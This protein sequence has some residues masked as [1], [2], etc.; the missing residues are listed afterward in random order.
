MMIDV[1]YLKLFS[2]IV[3]IGNSFLRQINGF[4]ESQIKAG[5]V[6]TLIP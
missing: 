4:V 5:Y 3:V 1:Y 2:M 6:Y